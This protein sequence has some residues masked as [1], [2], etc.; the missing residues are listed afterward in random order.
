[1][2]ALKDITTTKYL[3]AFVLLIAISM[4]LEC[5]G[6]RLWVNYR[7]SANFQEVVSGVLGWT[8]ITGIF[9]LVPI[10]AFRPRSEFSIRGDC[11][12]RA[13]VFGLCILTAFGVFA[14]TVIAIASAFG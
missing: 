6:E 14:A 3:G 8:A 13:Q 11:K 1:M 9:A 10:S 12:K 5:I 4:I 7:I 2:T